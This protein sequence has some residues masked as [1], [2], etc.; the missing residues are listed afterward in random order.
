M[1]ENICKLYDWQEVDSQNILAAHITPS[2]NNTILEQ[3]E[4]LDKHFSKE[5]T[6]MANRHEKML[7]ITNY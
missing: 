6:Q 2:N 4:N 5:D 7:N 1:G 3:A